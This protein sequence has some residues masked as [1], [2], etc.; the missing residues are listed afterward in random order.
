MA[1]FKGGRSEGA[2]A[3]DIAMQ[4]SLPEKVCYIKVNINLA[5]THTTA[6]AGQ[7]GVGLREEWA[8]GAGS[9]GACLLAKNELLLA[10]RQSEPQLML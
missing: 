6:A 7:K 8:A 2:W 10:A 4:S 5:H 9:R 3:C 1:N